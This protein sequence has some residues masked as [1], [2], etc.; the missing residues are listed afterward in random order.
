MIHPPVWNG[1]DSNYW[2]DY[3][4]YLWFKVTDYEEEYWDADYDG[5]PNWVLDEIEADQDDAQDAADYLAH[6]LPLDAV[7]NLAQK[8]ANWER[9]LDETYHGGM[10]YVH[11]D[12]VDYYT[13]YAVPQ[14]YYFLKS[15]HSLVAPP[16]LQVGRLG[17]LRGD[18]PGDCGSTRVDVD[19]SPVR[20]IGSTQ[21]SYYF[22]PPD[23]MTTGP[24]TLNVWNGM[25]GYKFPVFSMKLS[26][27]IDLT[28]L[29]PKMYP[30]STK[31][32]LSLTGINGMQLN[33]WTG[34]GFNPDLVSP[35]DLGT[36][37]QGFSLNDQTR[38]G[39]I[40][41]RVTN[42]SP[43]V[44]AIPEIT[45][46]QRT[47]ILDAQSFAPA[48]EFHI[49]ATA[50][51]LRDGNF[52]VL[53]LAVATLKPIEGTPMTPPGTFPGGIPI[54][55]VPLQKTW[56]FGAALRPVSFG[57]NLRDAST[58]VTPQ[59]Q[60]AGQKYLEARSATKVNRAAMIDAWKKALATTRPQ[61]KAA[62]E[63]AAKGIR[64]C[65]QG[66]ERFREG[67]ERDSFGGQPQEIRATETGPASKENTV[68]KRARDCTEWDDCRGAKCVARRGNR[69][70]E[71]GRA[72]G[73]GTGRVGSRVEGGGWWKRLKLG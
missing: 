21:S 18:F 70:Q 40:L 22:M 72:S 5:A 2:L 57:G 35:S 60:E 54:S 41:V 32:S 33:N 8:K 71:C 30:T 48:G 20:F 65:I 56:P 53:G 66:V 28:L 1:G 47:W 45:G 37:P 10:S 9:W 19:G 17:V 58:E 26:M 24:H 42:A 69:L 63:N 73:T 49:D 4:N 61:F 27:S 46:D 62:Y 36:L 31:W 16:I 38:Q 55:A 23:T 39:T 59:T 68:R 13:S 64:S 67:I 15:L 29:H 11:K 3:L 7:R 52:S 43:T 25:F 44:I 50:N 51:A 6:H 14:D 12:N 34:G